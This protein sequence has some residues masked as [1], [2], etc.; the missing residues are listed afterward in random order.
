MR[1]M[2][3]NQLKKMASGTVA[4]NANVL[5]DYAIVYLRS[6]KSSTTLPLRNIP[7]GDSL[8]YQLQS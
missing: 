7:R 2:T 3:E 8:C 1:F 5:S 4:I 6:C